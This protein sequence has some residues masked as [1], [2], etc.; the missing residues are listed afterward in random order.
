PPDYTPP[1]APLGAR[2]AQPP[3]FGFCRPRPRRPGYTRPRLHPF[4]AGGRGGLPP[5]LWL[6]PRAGRDGLATPAAWQPAYP[7]HRPRRPGYPRCLATLTAWLPSRPGY[8]HG[9]ATLTAWL[10]S[11]PG[12][13]HG[14][15]TP[16]APSGV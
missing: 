14:L 7:T 2:G 15:A 12:Y 5:V 1:L 6:L 4:I 8:P 16:A 13:P 11:R 9:L 3:S 10:P